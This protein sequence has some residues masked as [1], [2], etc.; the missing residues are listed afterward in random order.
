MRLNEEKYFSAEAQNEY[1][2]VSQFKA[3]AK[4]EAEAMAEISGQYEREPTTA[5]LV[6]SYVDA[7]FEGTLDVVVGQH[8]EIVKRDGTLKSEYIKADEIISRVE[9]DQLF[10]EYMSGQKQVIMEHELFGYPWKIKIDSYHPNKIVDL[11][12]MR[13][14]EDVYSRDYGHR[15]FIEAWGYDIQ[16]AVYQK[17]EQLV[18]GRDEPLPFY[19]AVATKEKVPDIAVIQIPQPVLDTA[20]RIVEAKIDRFALIKQGLVD[21]IRCEKCDYCKQTKTL[22]APTVYEREETE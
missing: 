15:S 13:D 2:S 4:C 9:R 22:T 16:G 6:G 21:P 14:M 1:F 17:I 5:L 11:K 10:M 18:S 20:L 8:P 12:V 3:F 19:L 7:H